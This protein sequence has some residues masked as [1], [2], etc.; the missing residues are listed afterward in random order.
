MNSDKIKEEIDYS[1]HDI[2]DYIRKDA[3]NT[4]DDSV[5]DSVSSTVYNS[6]V[7]FLL[8]TKNSTNYVVKEFLKQYE[9]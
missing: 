3:Y 5:D 6:V 7:Y 4:V 2:V 8:I 1:V 9:F